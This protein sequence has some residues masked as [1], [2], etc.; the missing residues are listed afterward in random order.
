MTAS[1]DPFLPS[2][3][4][5][6]ERMVADQLVIHRGDRIL[7]DQRLLGNQRPK[8][9]RDWPHVAVGQLVPRLR[10]RVGKLLR[11]LQVMP[12]N[13]LVARV[14]SQSEVR[15]QYGHRVLLGGIVR[16]RHR[17]LRSSALGLPLLS[18]CRALCQF[19]FVLEQVLQVLEVPT[20]RI[21]CPRAFQAT[22][23]RIH[24]DAIA[25]AILPAA[26]LLLDRKSTRL[27]SDILLRIARAMRLA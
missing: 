4:A 14:K 10:E 22:G 5:Y 16:I 11:I 6:S 23:D 7:P 2:A 12:G 21:R 26:P 18:S 25:K 27:N 24:A 3:V 8:I 9:P 13:L 20:R 1:S 15:R 19:P 17:A